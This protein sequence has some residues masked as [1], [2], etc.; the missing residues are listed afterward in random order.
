MT[1]RTINFTDWTN[2]TKDIKIKIIECS[3]LVGDDGITCNV[4]EDVRYCKIISSG[5]SG[6]TSAGPGYKR[7]KDLEPEDKKFA[8]KM[9]KYMEQNSDMNPDDARGLIINTH[10]LDIHAQV[11]RLQSGELIG[12]TLWIRQEGYIRENGPD[13]EESWS[14]N[15]HF[16]QDLNPIKVDEMMDHDG[17]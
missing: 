12:G 6:E 13:N 3:R 17:Y 8:E 16:D 15:G 10:E 7:I 5:N 4:H 1:I 14:M 2:L 11:Y 9:L